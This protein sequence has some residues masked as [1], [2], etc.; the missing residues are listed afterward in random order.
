MPK[1]CNLPYGMYKLLNII[2]K[3]EFMDSNLLQYDT[4][5][6]VLLLV[7]VA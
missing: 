2:R 7:A 1:F 3:S 5:V 6:A 4:L